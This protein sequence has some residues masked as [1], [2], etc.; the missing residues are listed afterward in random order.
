MGFLHLGGLTMSET[1]KG[2]WCFTPAQFNRF[3]GA[4]RG[5]GRYAEVRSKTMSEEMD[6]VEETSEE[7]FPASDAPGWAMGADEKS[8]AVSNNRELQR[9]EASGAVLQYRLDGGSIVLVHTEVP[10]KLRGHK[11]GEKLAA[12]GLDFARREKLRVVVRCP[13]VREYVRRH[14]E[15]ADIITA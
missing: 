1:T 10:V 8:P 7:S 2:V 12:A 5:C 14:P 6:P 11:L 4:A 13:F 9:F 3:A 15:Y